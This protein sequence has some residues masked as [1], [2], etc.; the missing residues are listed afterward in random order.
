MKQFANLFAELANL[1]AKLANLFAELANLFAKLGNFRTP[2]TSDV[3]MF[4]YSHVRI[5]ACSH[6]RIHAC[7]HV[8]RM[9]S[10][11]LAFSK[12]NWGCSHVR[13]NKHRWSD[14]RII[15]SLQCPLRNPIRVLL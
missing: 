11:A 10:R 14:R 13:I 8:R 5:F 15:G 1:F 6:V 2:L 9:C 3:L 7:P 12:H 4:A